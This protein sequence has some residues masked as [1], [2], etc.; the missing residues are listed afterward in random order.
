[1]SGIE[2]DLAGERVELGDQELEWLLRRARGAAGSSAAAAELATMLAELRGSGRRRRGPI[3]LQRG[4][5]R[6]LRALVAAG[7]PPGPRLE[8]LRLLLNGD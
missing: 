4:E 5:R 3:V 7:D 1:V 6:A 2:F 8:R